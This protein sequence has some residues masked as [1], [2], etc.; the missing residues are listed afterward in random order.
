[1]IILINHETLFAMALQIKEPLYVKNI[2]FNKDLGELHIYIDFRKGSKFSC[3]ICGLSEAS[4]HDTIEKTWRHM[5][6]FQYKAFIHYRTPRVICP[7]DGI[8][9]VDTPWVAP[10]SGFTL[11]FETLVLQLAQCMAVL[12]IANL[13]DENDTVL[14]RIIQRYVNQAQAVANYSDVRQVGVD[15]TATKRGHNYVTLFVDMEQAKVIHVTEGKDAATIKNFKDAL[16]NHQAQPSQITDFCAD[17]S[18]A[19][20]KGI[21]ENFPYACLTFDKFHVLKLLNEAVDQVRRQEQKNVSELKFSRYLWLFNPENLSETKSKKLNVLTQMNL[22]TAKAYRMKLVLQDVYKKAIGRIDA[23]NKLQKW[24]QWAVRCRLEP[25]K[26]F[27]KTLKKNWPGILNYFD[28]RLTNAIL[29]G[30]NSIVQSART[31]AKGYR[32]VNNFI[33]IIYLLAGKLTFNFQ[34]TDASNGRS[35]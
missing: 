19:F 33:A 17:M 4:I 9:L 16:P 8:H 25:V 32:N 11:L 27:A 28:S 23:M 20:R 2:E 6:F 18:P 29:E 12:Q 1:M 13:V 24:Y 14:W 5:N 30:T 35:E 34:Q 26:D 10:G 21:Q 22:K 7:N 15:E 3:P 31:R